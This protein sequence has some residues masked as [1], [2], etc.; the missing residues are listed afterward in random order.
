MYWEEIGIRVGE[1]RARRLVYDK[2]LRNSTS[3]Q[4]AY[5][6]GSFFVVVCL[7]FL[8]HKDYYF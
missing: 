6:A 8:L 2:A 5:V 4:L 7:V 3:L 1:G